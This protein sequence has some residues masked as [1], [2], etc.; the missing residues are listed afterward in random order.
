MEKGLSWLT[1]ASGQ[2]QLLELLGNL[3]KRMGCVFFETY[4]VAN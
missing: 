4:L 1:Y 2:V 3:S